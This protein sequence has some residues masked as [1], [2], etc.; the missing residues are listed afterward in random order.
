MKKGAHKFG[1]QN[2]C[3]QDKRHMITSHVLV[4]AT[5]VDIWKKEKT[6]RSKN[7]PAI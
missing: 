1:Q 6:D 2:V 3:M 7:I 5:L 4:R